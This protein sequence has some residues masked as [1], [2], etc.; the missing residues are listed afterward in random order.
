MFRL[1]SEKK[2]NALKESMTKKPDE[3]EFIVRIMKTQLMDHSDNVELATDDGKFI[4]TWEKNHFLVV[5]F[6]CFY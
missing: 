6:F 2:A 1:R 4:R 5:N 3:N